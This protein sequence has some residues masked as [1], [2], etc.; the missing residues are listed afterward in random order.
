MFPSISPQNMTVSK[1]LT[2]KHVKALGNNIVAIN[3]PSRAQIF[4]DRSEEQEN[5]RG[6][7][8]EKPN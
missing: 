8:S 2:V 7:K 3:V 6:S 1:E 4:T 5:K